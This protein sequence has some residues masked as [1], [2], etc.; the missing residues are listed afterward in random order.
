VDEAK[1][2]EIIRRVTERVL[3]RLMAEGIFQ[4]DQCGTLVI[5][6]D[7]IP[8]AMLLD[9]YLKKRFPAGITCALL[10][11]AIALDPA[12]ERIDATGREAQRELLASVK[13]YERVVLAM[14]AQQMLRR[15]AHGEDAGFAGQMILRA[16][17]LQKK[18]T[19][20]LDYDPPKFRRGTFFEELGSA[21]AA[22]RDM[23]TEVVSLVPTLRQADSGCELLTEDEVLQAYANG[24]RS[25][26]C[27]KG[28]IV[29]P[30]AK[31]K[32]NE[33]GIAI[34]G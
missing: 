29:T 34:E 12:F 28:A 8:E 11:P 16:I 25:I 7:F 5:V 6:P 23:G 32:A 21:I 24:D 26:R 22:L 14:P 15:I 17:L 10:E 13:F 1:I 20:L 30:L 33:L 9:E 18:V 31:D 19:V 27:A 4:P 3:E 2:R